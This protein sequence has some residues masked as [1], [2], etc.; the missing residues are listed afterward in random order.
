MKK[1]IQYGIWVMLPVLILTNMFIFVSGI[2]L[3]NQISR[4]EKEIKKI[5]EQNI[6]LNTQTSRLDSLEYAASVAATL[7][8]VKR[9]T[10]VV[11]ENLKYALNR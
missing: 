11:L 7:D 3:S 4:F 9:S 1:F 8:F 5:H 2:M 6:A 10:P